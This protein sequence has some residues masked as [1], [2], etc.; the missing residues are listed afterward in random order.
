MPI[1][2][3]VGS[4]YSGGN[5]NR[6]TM[7]V[8][9]DTKHGTSIH[10][11][12][13]IYIYLQCKYMCSWLLGN[14]V[15]VQS[16][17]QLAKFKPQNFKLTRSMHPK[18]QSSNQRASQISC[19][20]HPPCWTQTTKVQA[21]SKHLRSLNSNHRAFQVQNAKKIYIAQTK[22]FLK[23]KTFAPFSKVQKFNA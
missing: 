14:Y 7:G 18:S 9:W 12:I 22:K 13:Y 19:L 23:F 16:T 2:N 1:K 15:H 8:Q 21:R 11:Y 4:L 20:E 3:S 10:I 5:S 6:N 17:H